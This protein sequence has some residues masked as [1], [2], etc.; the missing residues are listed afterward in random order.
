[1]TIP[2]LQADVSEA[3]E[4]ASKHVRCFE[5]VCDPGVY[6]CAACGAYDPCETAVALR[7]YEA[8]VRRLNE[9]TRG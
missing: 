4:R 7:E 9:A 6:F 3:I 5:S 1:V 8:A 2:E